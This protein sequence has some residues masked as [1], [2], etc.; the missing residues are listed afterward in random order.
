M[1]RKLPIVGVFGQGTRIG[2]DRTD[3]AREVGAM[4]ARLGAH[5]LTGGGY[6]VMEAVAQGFVSV[7]DRPGSS[8]GIVPRRTRGALDE[9]NCDRE[10]RAYPNDFVEIPIMTPLQPRENDWRNMPARN[11]INVFTPDAIVT[12]PGNA[13]T[14]NELDM[15]AAYRDRAALLPEERRTV[16]VGPVAEFTPEHRGLFVHAATVEAARTHLSRILVANGFHPRS[17]A[18]GEHAI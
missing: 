6:G 1:M 5:L 4:I 8:I 2:P 10:G 17:E 18:V 9:P 14:R 7:A 13:G 11:H 15:T 3:L 16:L 12:L